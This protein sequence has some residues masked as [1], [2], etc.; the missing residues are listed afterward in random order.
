MGQTRH[1]MAMVGGAA[2][3]FIGPVHQLGA[4]LGAQVDLVAGVFSADRD[5][6]LAAAVSYGVAAERCYPD[7]AT[8]FAAEAARDDGIDILAIAT[9]NHLHLPVAIE[10]ITAGVH[11]IS[12]KPATATLA[13]AEILREALAAGRSRYALTYTYSGYPMVREARA[14]VAAGAIGTVRK[15]VV[16]YAQGW[17]ARPLEASGNARAAWRT[18][19]ARSGPGG[20]SADIGVHAFHLAEYVTGLRVAA[21][22]P[23][24][25]PLVPGRTL[26]DDCNALLH[27]ENGAGGV[28]ISSQV[29]F[30]ERN[31]LS[32]QL[33]GD[34]GAL[35]WTIDAPDRLRLVRGDGS[36]ALLLPTSPDLLV[37]G[38][39]APT[40]GQGIIM[41]F[42]EIY[43][44]F[45]DAIDGDGGRIDGVL[46][47]I[48]AGL[49]GVRFFES[50]ATGTGW[51]D[52]L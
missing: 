10:A 24:A 43:R 49:R 2:G 6:S 52:L 40:L 15:I 34:G 21:M 22:L 9:P 51:I 36:V 1:G 7:T 4:K 16:T 14:R 8:M 35:H 45:V 30:G 39:F 33:Y 47:G 25:R 31:A 26:D 19:P 18:D 48:E 23:D 3:S 29:A 13:E 42:A 28:L 37:R 41:P 38:R 44:D 50:I 32:F 12:D 5:R 20:C 17:L 27:L 11:I 46:P